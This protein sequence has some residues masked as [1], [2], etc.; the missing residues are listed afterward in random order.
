MRKA[1]A[2]K[3]TLFEKQPLVTNRRLEAH[4]KA[5][6]GRDRRLQAHLLAKII[7]F[8]PSFVVLPFGCLLGA[9]FRCRFMVYSIQNDLFLVVMKLSTMATVVLK[10]VNLKTLL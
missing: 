7:T 5:L 2:Q 10:S 6:G 8:W 4:S 3:G 1:A 9:F